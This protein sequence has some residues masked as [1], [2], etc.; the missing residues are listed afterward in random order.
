M[1]TEN[2]NEEIKW[3]KQHSID[4][5]C[6]P[7]V[8]NE[9]IGMDFHLDEYPERYPSKDFHEDGR[10][11]LIKITTYR[12]MCYGAKHYYAEI[13]AD[14]IDIREDRIDEKG[15]KKT[16]SIGGYMGKEFNSLPREKQGEYERFYNIEAARVVTQQ[17]IDKD[18]DR[19]AG[20]KPGYKTNAFDTPTEA[21]ETA[22]KVAKIRFPK[23]WNFVVEREY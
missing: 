5:G 13:E 6:Y 12:G 9:D 16:Y 17:D 18:E 2:K 23:G 20:Y 3:A 11:C 15:N 14:G 7:D 19:W 10:K 4:N 8:F 22:L 21:E 1:D